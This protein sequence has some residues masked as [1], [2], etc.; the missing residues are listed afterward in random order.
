MLRN[1]SM[2]RNK[3]C[4]AQVQTENLASI[5]GKFVGRTVVII[6]N[7]AFDRRTFILLTSFTEEK[8]YPVLMNAA[9]K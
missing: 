1:T 3:S 8:K 4:E 9:I 6:L 2:N 7:K 5:N